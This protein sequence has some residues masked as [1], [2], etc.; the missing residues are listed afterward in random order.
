MFSFRTTSLAQQLDKSL[1]QGRVVCICT[2]GAYDVSGGTYTWELFARRGRLLKCLTL[3]EGEFAFDSEQAFSFTREDFAGADAVVVDLQDAGS[4]YFAPTRSVF[5]LMRLLES[6]GPGA[7][8]LYIVDHLNPS[9]RIVE[10]SMGTV[11]KGGAFP[12]T[13]HR[14]GLTLGELCLLYQNEINFHP[15]LH[16]ISA[17]AEGAAQLLPWVIS[18]SADLPGLFSCDMYSGG[19]LWRKTNFNPGLGTPRPY[20]YFGAPFL[21]VEPGEPIP[22]PEGVI[23]RPCTFVPAAGLYSGERCNG[24]QILLRPGFDYPSLSH[25]LQML[26]YFRA[27]C[28]QLRLAADFAAVLADPTLLD[29]VEGGSDWPTV[30]E[31]LKGE[32][33]KW[34]RKARK[35]TLYENNPY[36]IKG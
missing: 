21:K 9:G 35:F 5:T 27:H 31:Y 28:P 25:T 24:Y 4:R 8:S 32:E 20:E 30:R 19:Y 11:T 12:K 23:L 29:F 17:L 15:P 6:L 2:P 18:P 22:V 26:R 14:H 10:G 7:P 1:H 36:R 16:V 13:C 3:P 34:I 33:Q